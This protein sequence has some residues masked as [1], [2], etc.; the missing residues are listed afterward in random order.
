MTADAAGDNVDHTAKGTSGQPRGLFWWAT[1]AGLA[2]NAIAI[3]TSLI[4]AVSVLSEMRVRTAALEAGQERLAAGLE[5]LESGQRDLREVLAI[6]RREQLDLGG[7][8]GRLESSHEA[9]R[10][11]LGIQNGK[12]EALSADVKALNASQAIIIVEQKGL[13]ARMDA[14]EATQ[15]T[16]ATELR[17]VADSQ[18]ATTAQMKL[19]AASQ[20]K[21]LGGLETKVAGLAIDVS[22]LRDAASRHAAALSDVDSE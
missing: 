12:L 11:D 6:M 4:V 9:V 20:E 7:Q 5:R 8:V 10:V 14:F 2:A 21:R 13:V 16:I 1:V 17:R 3:A 19:T 15:E 22:Q 18:V